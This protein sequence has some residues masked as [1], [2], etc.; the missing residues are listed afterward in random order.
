MITIDLSGLISDRS[1]DVEAILLRIAG[2]DARENWRKHCA[3]IR[4]RT[5]TGGWYRYNE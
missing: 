1:D 5:M 2:D 3:E 4:G